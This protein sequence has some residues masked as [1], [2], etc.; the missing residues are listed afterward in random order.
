MLTVRFFRTIGKD[1]A[2]QYWRSIR[3][4]NLTGEGEIIGNMAAGVTHRPLG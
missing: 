3:A 1:I 4:G 2:V